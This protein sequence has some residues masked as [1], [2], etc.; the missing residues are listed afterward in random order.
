MIDIHAH[1]LVRQIAAHVARVLQC[2]LHRFRPMI[3][4]VANACA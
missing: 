1:E 3:Q 2:V 4:A